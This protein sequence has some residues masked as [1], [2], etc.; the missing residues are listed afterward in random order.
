MNCLI[1]MHPK[2]KKIYPFTIRPNGEILI[3]TTDPS[4]NEDNVIV[5]VRPIQ[6]IDF[7]T[8]YYNEY[9]EKESMNV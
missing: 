7:E 5:T 3:I 6:F 8:G 4:I 1:V 9:L 2:T